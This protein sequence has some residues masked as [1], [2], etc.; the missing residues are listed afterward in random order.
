MAGATP[1][2]NMVIKLGLDDTDFGRGVANSKKQVTYLAKEMSANMKIADMAGDK[3]GKLGARY[4]S[5][6]QIMKA[7]QNQVAALKRSYDESFVDGQ[8]TES[9][10]RLAIQLQDANG[11]LAGYQGQLQNTA[12]QLARLQVETQGFTGGLN[13]FGDSAI[14]NGAKLTA[15]GD[16]ASK[17][18]GTLTKSVTIPLVALGAAAVKASVDYESAFAGVKKTV[19]EQVDSNGKVIISYDDLS[20]GIR[21]MAKELPASASE[22]AAV[23]EQAGQLGIKTQDVLSFSRTMIDLGESTNM[24]ATDAATAIAKIANITGMTSDQYQ[25]FGSSVTALGNNF[26]TTESDIIMM[27]NRLASAGTLAGLSNQE[28]LGLATAMSSVGIEAEAGGTAMTQTLSAIEKAAVLGGS[29]VGD[30]EQKANSVGLSFRDVAVSVLKGGSA[31]KKTAAQMGMSNT[32]L[33]RTYEDA[34]KAADSLKSF[35]DIAGMSSEQFA[36]SWKNKPIEAIQAFIKGLGQLSEKGESATLALDDMG[37]KGIRQGNMLKSLALA[38]DTLTGAV[39]MSTQA[40]DENTAL[41]AEASKR[42]ETTESKLKM[43]KNEVTDVAIEFGGP[44]V[45]ALRDGVQASKPVIEFLGDMAK[46][47]SSLDKE[48]QQNI[49]K[50]ALIAA[51]AGPALKIFGS[52]TSVV[53]GTA[54]NIGKLSKNLVGLAAKAAEKKAV[55]S[56]AAEITTLGA[57][58]ASTSGALAGGSVATAGFATGLGAMLIPAG[59]AVGAIAAV[60]VAAYAGTKAYEAHQLA[61]AKWG[62]EVTKEEDKVITKSYELGNKAKADVAAYADG[63][64]SSANSVIK[65]NEEIVNSIQKAVDKEDERRKKSASKIDDPEAKK[66]AE[67]QAEYRASIDKRTVESAKETASNINKI[68]KDASDNKR[69]LSTE[70]RNFIAENY[71]KLSDSQLKAA[72]FD[73]DRR[74]AIESAYQKDLSKLSEKQLQDRATNVMRGLDEEKTWYDKQKSYL[75]EVYGE[76]TESYKREMKTLNDTNH[77]QTETMILGLAKLTKAQG[78]SLEN[79]SGAWE[80]YGWTTEEVAALVKNSGESSTKEAENLSKILKTMDMD[81]DAVKLDPKTGKLTVEGKEDLIQSLL[82]TN[83]WKDLS[84]DEKK[85]LVDGDEARIAFLDSATEAKKWEK[86]QILRKEIGIENSR[87]IQAIMESKDGLEKWKQLQPDEKELLAKNDSLLKHVFSSEEALNKWRE[88][89]V[90]TKNILADS[91]KFYG[92]IV[93]SQEMLNGWNALPDSVKKILGDNSNYIQN[94][95]QARQALSSWQAMPESIKKL[96]GDNSNVLAS[97]FSSSE[98]LAIWDRMPEQA[99]KLLGENSNFLASKEGATTELNNWA[100]NNP[101]PKSLDATNKTA[102]PVASA[103]ATIVTLSGRTVSL[104]ATNNVGSIVNNVITDLNRLPTYRGISIGIERVG[105]GAQIADMLKEKGTNFHTGGDII[106]NDQKGPLYKEIVHEPGKAPYIPLGRNV[107]IPNAKKGT[108][109]YTASRTKSLMQRA[110]I[111]R[112]A[113]GVGI[114]EDSKIINNLRSIGNTHAQSDVRLNVD[115]S[116]LELKLDSMIS[117]FKDLLKKDT[118]ITLDGEPVSKKIEQMIVRR[119]AN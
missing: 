8:A 92:A 91:G 39:S 112:Y 24:S 7:Q 51:S 19:D 1:L 35:A 4:D 108:K 105:G 44:L 16:G 57:S 89:P 30:L 43:L 48:Q 102:G 114:P 106:V 113:D 115:N 95:E 12:G 73:K 40:W 46:K 27:T 45:D 65:S 104:D 14:A 72:G 23:A 79:M 5:L 56:M 50:W 26:A 116:N 78:F 80:K 93:G 96:L 83:K 86:Y 70:E 87:A 94:D 31:L 77:K 36:L 82:E 85:L 103:N 59:I 71:R 38:S 13:R 61:G 117:L 17:L 29:A 66:R 25:R 15:I 81:W 98:N 110:G 18:G 97:I 84:L 63:V 54:T 62:A 109:V 9:T 100:A 101:P 47:F 10:K 90:E 41:T 67:E 37:L 75:K 111:P 119:N 20:N 52:I 32:E 107:Y 64:Q 76:G 58:A 6:T 42:Y 53:G 60:G 88:M 99:K 55:A 118:V 74:I 11:K 69:N 22:I 68:M 49:I 28:M 21:A 2:G 34:G 33:R 3:L